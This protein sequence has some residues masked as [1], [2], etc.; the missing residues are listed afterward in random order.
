MNIAKKIIDCYAFEETSE[1]FRTNKVFF[2]HLGCKDL[3]LVII[4]EETIF[5]QYLP[6]YFQTE[7]IIFVSRHQSKRNIP[8]LSVH[9]PGNLAEA[10]LGGLPRKV[11]ISPANSMRNA[12]LEMTVQKEKLKLNAFSV[13]YECTHHGPSLDIPTMFVEIGSSVTE[14]KNLKAA[15]AV[16]YA[17][18]SSIVKESTAPAVLG[19]GGNH[20]NQVF[21]EISLKHEIAFGH[22][23]PNY[24]L[25]NVD[26]NILMQC[27]EKTFETVKTTILDWD[28]IS[29]KDRR[30]IIEI[31]KDN[32]QVKRTKDF[33]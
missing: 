17:A 13:S 14:W 21:T 28:R 25:Q 29:G 11:S 32:L 5:G 18:I 26:S 4:N 7:L 19:I 30:R 15:E 3:K 22:I 2:K 33:L 9:T 27:I 23:I 24:A 1:I 10:E 6:N 20:V 16:A 31:L 8:T 12:L